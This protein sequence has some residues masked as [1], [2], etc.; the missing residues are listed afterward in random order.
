MRVIV[1]YTRLH[2]LTEQAVRKES[3][4]ASFCPMKSEW[5]YSHLLHKLWNEGD[6]FILVEHDI[7]PW[8]G[9]L[10][11]IWNCPA[12]WCAY[13][14]ECNGGIGLYHTFGCAKISGQLIN[15][16]PDVW[17]DPLPWHRLDSH[18]CFEASRIGQVPHPHRPP[19]THLKP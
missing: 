18:L 1:P 7:L 8:P 2:P 5:D 14:Y 4:W 15:R 13:S 11:E 3:K 9:A 12:E 10:G 6:N 19:V 17:K 16:L